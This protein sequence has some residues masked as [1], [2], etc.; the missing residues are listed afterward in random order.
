MPSSR[1]RAAAERLKSGAAWDDFCETVRSAGHIV[2]EFEGKIT[3]LDR[4]EWYRFLTRLL[5]NGFERYMENCEPD[6]PRLRDAPWRQSINFQSPDQDHLLAEFVDGSYD[7]RIHGNRG[8]LPYFVIAAWSA[9]QPDD[10]A[11]RDWAKHGVSG[12]QE[13]DPATLTTTGFLPSEAIEFDADGNFEI[14]VS[15]TQPAGTNNWLSI[16]SDCVGILVRTLY[17]DRAN[18]VAPTMTIARLDN[19]PPRPIAADEVS[20]GLAKAGQLVLAY[21]ELV[22]SWWQENLSKRANSIRFSRALYLS[23]G[24]VPDRHHGFGAW[25]KKADEAL[26]LHFTPGPCEYWIFQLCNVW[27]ENL[28]CYEE[29][30]GYTTKSRARYESDG[31]VF[32]VIADA[33]PEVGG[34]WLD[35]YG[36]VHGGMSL[37]LIKAAGEP[38]QVALYRLPLK[39]LRSV[40]LSGLP[41]EQAII[42]GEVTD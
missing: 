23:N 3:E 31:S 5:R 34:V 24:G 18:T 2:D 27:Q 9:K 11:A 1:K 14:I 4:S 41:N 8:T 26:V 6:R 40:G 22:R 17:H 38:P 32:V 29:G 42:S 7:Y 13:F 30:Q 28:D 33:D 39:T 21:V 36:H 37:R 15:Q 25:E 16:T 35:A 12:L 10:L 19:V 20:A